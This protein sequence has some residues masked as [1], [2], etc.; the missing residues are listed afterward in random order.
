ML[1]KNTLRSFF[2]CT[3]RHLN[4][5]ICDSKQAAVFFPNSI[6]YYN[7]LPSTNINALAKGG[8]GSAAIFDVELRRCSFFSAVDL[9][10]LRA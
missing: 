8:S 2:A 10:D 3:I 4:I 7:L 1:K 9:A 5:F 6:A